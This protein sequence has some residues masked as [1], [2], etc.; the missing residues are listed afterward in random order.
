MNLEQVSSAAPMSFSNLKIFECTIHAIYQGATYPIV[1][2]TEED[3]A[4]SIV[5]GRWDWLIKGEPGKTYE[6]SRRVFQF[7]LHAHTTDRLHYQ[8][9]GT[10]QRERRRLA[11]S[12]KGYI[13]MYAAA[14]A[15]M[16]F[17]LEPLAWDGRQLRCRWRDHE[18]HTVKIG[19]YPTDGRPYDRLGGYLDHLNVYTEYAESLCEFLITPLR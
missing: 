9:C 1:L 7:K 10:G 19:E 18:G 8:M 15:I 4:K 13:G 2:S 14:E 6:D 3:Y 17:K 5:P 16:T 12:N 11:R